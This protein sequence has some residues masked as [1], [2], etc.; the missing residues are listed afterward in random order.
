MYTQVL[1]VSLPKPRLKRITYPFHVACIKS[2]CLK[3][4]EAQM[5]DRRA[6]RREFLVAERVGIEPT[7]RHIVSGLRF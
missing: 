1:G 5:G 3:I 7:P 6:A 4:P 2:R